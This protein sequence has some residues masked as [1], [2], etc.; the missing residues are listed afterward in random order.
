MS[1]IPVLDKVLFPNHRIPK[2]N[3]GLGSNVDCWFCLSRT[4]VE[5]SQH[6]RLH[7]D[8]GDSRHSIAHG[9]IEPS[10]PMKPTVFLADLRATAT[11]WVCLNH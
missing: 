9:A 6:M 2:R 8:F 11:E 5:S 4:V 3:G 7:F 1:V 10:G